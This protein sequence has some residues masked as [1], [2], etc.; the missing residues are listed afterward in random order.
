M[1]TSLKNNPIFA[2]LSRWWP[3]LYILIVTALLFVW[4]SNWT[5]DDPYITYRYAENL[6]N[7]VGF[8][9]NPGERVL[10]TTTPLFTLLLTSL[11]PIWDNLPK[12]AN[13]I[14]AI[15]LAAGA[16]LLWDLGKTWKAPPIGWAALL[17]YPTF[18]LL[19]T[20]LGSEMPL[21]LALCLGAFAFYARSSYSLS[22]VF[23]ALAVLARPDGILVGGVLAL[24]YL[25]RVRRH[26]PLKAVLIF[27]AITLPWIIFAWSYF[28]SPIPVTLLTKQNQGAMPISERFAPG[29]LSI[30]N[31]Y[32]SSSHYRIEAALV[33]F[34]VGCLLWRS[35][36][37]KDFRRWLIFFAWNILYFIAYSFLGVSRYFWYYA[38][39]VP[40]IV[41]WIGLGASSVVLVSVHIFK[42]IWKPGKQNI[43]AEKL[44]AVGAA[45]TVLLLVVLAVSQIGGLRNLQK[46]MDIR[47]KVYRA[48]GEWLQLTTHPDAEIASLEIGIIGYHSQRPMVD[49]AGLIKPKVAARLSSASNFDQVAIWTAEHFA[50]QYL[51]IGEQELPRLEKKFV[52]N[53]CVLVKQFDGTMYGYP[54]HLQLYQCASP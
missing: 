25:I 51:V 33:F 24:D 29:F 41:A 36:R 18:P 16:V 23:A 48:V 52:K 53:N 40:G 7:G 10:S 37:D 9:Y 30:A 4:F 46:S 1:F 47:V 3:L 27:L 44:K 26:I 39:L 14:G 15:S 54:K 50:P 45:L 12:L 2:L 19:L 42:L 21:Y 13:L 22:A 49:F 11:Y 31:Q 5:Y 34:G 43:S 38:P 17:L 20:T 35:C 6:A 8:V 28:G 32:V